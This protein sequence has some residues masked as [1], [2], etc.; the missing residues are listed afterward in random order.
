MR[1]IGYTR[2]FTQQELN[3]QAEVLMTY[4]DTEY[5]ISDIVHKD[6]N[7]WTYRNSRINNIESGCTL[8][9][10][11]IVHI[12]NDINDLIDLIEMLDTRGIGLM[13]YNEFIA[14]ASS[15]GRGM[16]DLLRGAKGIIDSY[17][18]KNIPVPKT[19]SMQ[20]IQNGLEQIEKK[21]KAAVKKEI[22]EIP[23]DNK[24]IAGVAS[25]ISLGDFEKQE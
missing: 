18:R 9:V 17:K 2:G 19:K 8:V 23:L 15:F 16:V 3:R 12:T 6:K 11:S 5:I 7:D 13:A 4:T 10:E 20:R 25:N 21:Y 1:F 14:T 22:Q 24:V